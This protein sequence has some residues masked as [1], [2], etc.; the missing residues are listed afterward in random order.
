M[1]STAASSVALKYV[2]KLAPCQQQSS[3]R[4]MVCESHRLWFVYDNKTLRVASVIPREKCEESPRRLWMENDFQL[5]LKLWKALR[6][7]ENANR[8]DIK[9]CNNVFQ[10][11]ITDQ[12]SLKRDRKK[13]FLRDYSILNKE[14]RE[15]ISALEDMFMSQIIVKFNATMS[16]ENLF[17]NR[18]RFCSASE[19]FVWSKLETSSS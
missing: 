5:F 17:L 4:H 6:S 16:N 14:K 13:R 8:V 18:G 19:C 11:L 9:S 15:V 12:S 1:L 3:P 2:H 7:R 10:L